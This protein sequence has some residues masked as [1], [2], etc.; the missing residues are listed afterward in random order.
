MRPSMAGSTSP[1][2]DQRNRKRRCC[3]SSRAASCSWPTVFLSRMSAGTCRA[4]RRGSSARMANSSSRAPSAGARAPTGPTTSTASAAPASPV[5]G[6]AISRSSL[7]RRTPRASRCRPSNMRTCATPIRWTSISMMSAC[8]KAPSSVG[9]TSGTRAGKPW[10]AARWMSRRSRSRRSPTASP[11]RRWKKPGSMPASACSSASRSASTRPSRTSSSRH[12]RNSPPA[13]TCSTTPPG[14][15][16]KAS[17]VRRRRPWPS[18][19]SPIPASRSD[20]PASR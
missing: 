5:T 4:S 3:Q 13:A 12:G 1:R 11:A 6:M 18:S 19:M 8:R 17:P 10:P 2:T 15:R 16:A 20:L 9:R 7:C 14:S